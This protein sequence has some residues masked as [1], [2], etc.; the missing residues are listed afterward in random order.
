VLSFAA[1]RR[2]HFGDARRD[3]SGR[4]L[5]A[6]LGLVAIAEQDARGYALRSRCDLVCEGFSPIQIVQ[7]DGSTDDVF[8]DRQGARQL[9][10]GAMEQGVKDG[11]AFPDESIRLEPQEKL[12]EIVR[13]SQ[14]LALS[15]EG[16][17]AGDE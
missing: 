1:L 15:G 2:L 17:E 3:V 7:P 5:L 10:E 9:Y 6:A 8:I 13:K 14:E 16:G 11:F 4:A 12:V